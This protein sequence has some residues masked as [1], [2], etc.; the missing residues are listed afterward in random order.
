MQDKEVAHNRSPCVGVR[1][2]L[3]ISNPTI[4]K[5]TTMNRPPQPICR[6]E[7]NSNTGEASSLLP[8]AMLCRQ[9]SYEMCSP[10]GCVRQR[11]QSSHGSEW[12]SPTIIRELFANERTR[13]KFYNPD[14]MEAIMAALDAE[15][16]G[17]ERGDTTLS[18]QPQPPPRKDEI[19]KQ[20]RQQS[21]EQ[22]QVAFMDLFA[23]EVA[24]SVQ[25]FPC[26]VDQATSFRVS[27]P[28][29]HE[30]HDD[31]CRP[32]DTIMPVPSEHDKRACRSEKKSASYKVKAG[33]TD[34]FIKRPATTS[35]TEYISGHCAAGFDPE[36]LICHNSQNELGIRLRKLKCGHH[37][38]P[39]CINRWLAKKR[40][41]PYCRQAVS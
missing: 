24:M 10:K 22:Q 7:A 28:R 3:S 13:R 40:T 33:L 2:F 18:Q 25:P 5:H 20:E 9:S 19:S 36:C 14:S 17:A 27:W 26:V 38:C 16:Q 35:N 12:L 23:E 31:D 4:P 15:R 29:W 34:K 21:Q 30:S 37:Y 41:C 39:G 8:P 1:S 11:N 32:F 6:P